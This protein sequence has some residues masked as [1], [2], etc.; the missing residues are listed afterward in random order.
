MLNIT[1]GTVCLGINKINVRCV[2]NQGVFVK[3][4]KT[5]KMRGLFAQKAQQNHQPTWTLRPSRWGHVNRPMWRRRYLSFSLHR[6]LFVVVFAEHGTNKAHRACEIHAFGACKRASLCKIPFLR[7]DTIPCGTIANMLI[8]ENVCMLYSQYTRTHEIRP[9]YSHRPCCYLQT[10]QPQ[11]DKAF[12]HNGHHENI[13]DCLMNRTH[14]RFERRP[15]PGIRFQFA[16]FVVS[17]CGCWWCWWWW[18]NS[19]DRALPLAVITNCRMDLGGVDVFTSYAL[20]CFF[21]RLLFMLRKCTIGI[22]FQGYRKTHT[23]REKIQS[24]GITHTS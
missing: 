22:I 1:L 18:C 6:N 16:I 21:S 3:A 11:N 15:A 23:M 19:I 4:I 10:R 9:S 2:C 7:S 5:V 14:C 20:Y 24:G 17:W 12:G 8:F 13:V